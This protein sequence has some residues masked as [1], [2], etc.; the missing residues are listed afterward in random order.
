MYSNFHK[1]LRN[2]SAFS[3]F[4]NVQFFLQQLAQ[5][6]LTVQLFYLYSCSIWLDVMWGIETDLVPTV[7]NPFHKTTVIRPFRPCVEL[8]QHCGLEGFL[9]TSQS[10]TEYDSSAGDLEL[11]VCVGGGWACKP[12]VSFVSN[13]VC[14]LCA[15]QGE[16]TFITSQY[17]LIS[18][19]KYGQ[20]QIQWS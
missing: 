13:W 20:D 3:I 5:H 11:M 19:F 2:S 16:C 7:A 1:I 9:H 10:N 12:W 18:P 4:F 15:C 8:V 6:A 14:P 17:H